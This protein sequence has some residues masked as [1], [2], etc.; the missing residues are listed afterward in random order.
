MSFRKPTAGS[1]YD[2]LTRQAAAMEAADKGHTGLASYYTEKGRI[3]VVYVGSGL[4]T[5]MGGSTG[6][7]PT[8][9]S[10]QT[11]CRTCSA[12]GI[13]RWDRRTREPDLCIGRPEQPS[14]TATDSKAVARLGT[15]YKV[16]ENDASGFRI[17]VAT[18]LAAMNETAG[19]PRTGRSPGRGSQIRT[20]V[21]RECFKLRTVRNLPTPGRLAATLAKHSRP[22]AKG[23]GRPRPRLLPARACRW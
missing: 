5:G 11:T 12:P 17:E 2:Y 14:P 16:Y 22:K 10:P 15:P 4:V 1:G 9:S 20:E 13:T 6:W 21:T 8:T 18:R 19:C 3:P 7:T 23:H